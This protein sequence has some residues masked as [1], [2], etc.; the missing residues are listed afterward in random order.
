MS[1]EGGKYERL[2]A[3]LQTQSASRVSMK[4]SEIATVLGIPGLPKSAVMYRTWW[5]NDARNHVQANAWL[6]AGYR[7]EQVDTNKNTVVFVRER[8]AHGVA[9]NAREFESSDKHTGP[10]PMI[11]ALKGTFSIEEGWDLTKPALD[12]E[13]LEAWEAKLDRMADALQENLSRK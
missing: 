8:A 7:T 5:S 1:G 9:E 11:G 3:Y 10:H 13:E 6:D 4:F 12:P 2:K